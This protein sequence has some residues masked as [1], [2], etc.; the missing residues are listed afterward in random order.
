MIASLRNMHRYSRSFMTVFV[1]LFALGG[2]QAAWACSHTA[3][4]ASMTDCNMGASCPENRA[5][6]C[7]VAHAQALPSMMLIGEAHQ[8]WVALPVN[9]GI[10]EPSVSMSGAAPIHATRTAVPTGPPIHLRFCS[11]LK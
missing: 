5:A 7:L 2:L 11:F 3:G 8:T 6:E 1:L 9:A 10:F 4:M